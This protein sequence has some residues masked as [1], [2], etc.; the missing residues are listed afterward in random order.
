MNIKHTIAATTIIL[1]TTLGTGAL[2]QTGVFVPGPATVLAPASADPYPS[3]RTSP[4]QSRAAP[5][6]VELMSAESAEFE[7]QVHTADDTPQVIGLNPGIYFVP[8]WGADRDTSILH[9]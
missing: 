7:E 1:A 5:E 3:G 8:A 6:R 2:I 4:T 9:I